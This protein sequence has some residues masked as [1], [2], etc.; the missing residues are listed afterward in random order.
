MKKLRTLTALIAVLCCSATSAYD[1][2]K[3]GIYYNLYK[4]EGG[5]GSV[6][7]ESGKDCSGNVVIPNSVTVEGNTYSV[8]GI[9]MGAFEDCSSLTSVTIPGS[10]TSIQQQTFRNCTNLTSVTILDGVTSILNDAFGNCSS[11][12]SITI[13]SSVTSIHRGTFNGTPWY[14]NQEDGLLYINNVLYEYKG[15]MPAGTSVNIKEGTTHINMS[16]FSQCSGLTSVTIPEGVVSIEHS[17][18]HG[19]SDLTSVTIPEGVTSIG[20]S[21]FYGCS[22]L[23][24]ITIP[25]S[26][27]VSENQLSINALT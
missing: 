6:W 5:A 23:T 27:Q 16:A 8:T 14:E 1:F 11:L 21:A 26:V 13:P 7:I 24:S 17:A 3:D 18:F 4:T 12:T 10:V 19:C 20:G 9:D 15:T 2:E 25:G 22:S